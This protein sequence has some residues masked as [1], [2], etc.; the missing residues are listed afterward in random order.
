MNNAKKNRT[1]S[2]KESL[3]KLDFN[4][5]L[6][7]PEQCKSQSDLRQSGKSLWPLAIALV[8][9]C[10]IVAFFGM[11]IFG[12]KSLN[13][14]QKKNT[15]SLQEEYYREQEQRKLKQDTIRKQSK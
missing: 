9:L 1:N 13:S 3:H 8:M 6:S 15:E 10:I 7:L 2:H 4:Q 14:D 12:N 5:N 11:I